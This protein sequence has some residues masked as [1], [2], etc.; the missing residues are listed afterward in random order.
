MIYVWKDASGNILSFGETPF[1]LSGAET[2]EQIETTMSAYENRFRLTA[3]KYQIVADDV[4][5]AIVTLYSNSGESSI[6][7]DVNGATVTVSLTAGVG[8]LPPISS[9]VVDS[10]IIQPADK[11]LFSAS[12]NGSL[13]IQA[14][15]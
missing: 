8:T 5:E 3:D 2:Q 14:V 10:I 7:V 1:V 15:E 4:D 9:E 12:G 6:D 11:T 13:V